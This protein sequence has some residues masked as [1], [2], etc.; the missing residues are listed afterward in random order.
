[1]NS[2]QTTETR[3]KDYIDSTEKTIQL[4]KKTKR[5][6]SF[7]DI[8]N[9]SNTILSKA[10]SGTKLRIRGLGIDRWHTLKGMETELN[11]LDEE[12]YYAGRVKDTG[13]FTTFSQLEITIL[14][15]K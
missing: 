3:R 6:I 11:L 9:I 4:H 7:N 12:E 1:M 2:Y 8:R 13:N 15:P 5:M 14:K 10:P